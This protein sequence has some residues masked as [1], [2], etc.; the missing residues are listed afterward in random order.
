M[1]L[2]LFVAPVESDLPP[3]IGD[4]SNNT[5]QARSSIRRPR[6]NVD[7]RP[8]RRRAA[9][10]R[11]NFPTPGPEPV[12]QSAPR[13]RSAYP[14]IESGNPPPPEAYGAPP[15]RTTPPEDTDRPTPSAESNELREA[16]REM[17]SQGIDV[18]DARLISLFG[19]RWKSA[20]DLE[21]TW[22]ERDGDGIEPDWIVCQ[23]QHRL[24][25]LALTAVRSTHPH[26]DCLA[27][28]RAMSRDLLDH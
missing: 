11:D 1:G 23:C 7:S 27:N 15:L 8:F 9:L 6:R 3:K 20:R 2:P 5:R 13:P 19:E 10:L 18:G 26:P 17:Q 12:P 16:L 22:L 4:K 14:W 21:S 25:P 28:P 24:S